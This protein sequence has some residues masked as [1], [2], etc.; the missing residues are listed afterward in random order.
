MLLPSKL[1]K[2]HAAEAEHVLHT[3]VYRF[4]LSELLNAGKQSQKLLITTEENA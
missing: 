1:P 4:P 2:L 3:D